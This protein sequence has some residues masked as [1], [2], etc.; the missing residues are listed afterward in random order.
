MVYLSV[1][2]DMVGCFGTV[3]NSGFH[4]GFL[5]W[6]GDDVSVLNKSYLGDLPPENL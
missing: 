5:V 6:G 2:Y 4:T 3:G 1:C